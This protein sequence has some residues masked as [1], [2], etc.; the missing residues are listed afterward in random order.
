MVSSATENELF[1]TAPN[2]MND[3]ESWGSGGSWGGWGSISQTS[4]SLGQPTAVKRS[5]AEWNKGLKP[6]SNQRFRALGFRRGFK[7]RLQTS[8]PARD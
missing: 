4:S 7:P 5:E 8:P 3:Q 2:L 6:R 1:G